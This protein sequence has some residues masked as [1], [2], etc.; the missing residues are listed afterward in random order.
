MNK[1]FIIFGTLI[2]LS[3]LSHYVHAQTNKTY[4]DD[5]RVQEHLTTPQRTL[6]PN[7]NTLH[8]TPMPSASQ[9]DAVQLTENELTQH[10]KLLNRA[11]G[12]A[13]LLNDGQNVAYLL[14]AYQKLPTH[15]QD[16][17]LLLWSKAVIAYHQQRHHDAAQYY[18][19]LL[20]QEEKYPFIQLQAIQNLLANRDF[21]AAEQQLTELSSIPNLPTIIQ[22]AITHYR[23]AI[24]NHHR[25]K[26]SGGMEYVEDSNINQAPQQTDLGTHWKAEEAQSAHGFAW[27][28]GVSKTF[29]FAHGT[30]AEMRAHLSGKYYWDSKQYN[31]ARL[32]ISLGG[33]WQNAQHSWLLLPFAEHTRYAGGKAG[34]SKM[35]HFSDTAGINTQWQYRFHPQWQ[36]NTGI[37]YA[38]TRYQTRP[39]LDGYYYFAYSNIHH[40][41]TPQ[42][43]WQL[44]LDHTHNQTQDP[45]DSYTR[46]GIHAAWGKEWHNGISTQ[47][48]AGYAKRRYHGPMPI[49][50]KTQ[51]NREYQL[52]LSLWHK[53]LHFLGITPRLM[54]QYQKTNSNIPLYRHQ[55]GRLM[56]ELNKQ[57]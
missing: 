3:P 19:Q 27:Q 45:D 12:A 15:A 11:L 43:F 13:L 41:P 8:S 46:S 21:Q 54:W 35:Q 44:G 20:A 50:M 10:P 29:S 56:L 55:K 22:Q 18:R 1:H 24:H 6:L 48:G 51:N 28:T 53:D 25:W 39:H 38:Q 49:F 47:I 17:Q 40:Q 37:E 2:C 42:Q 9:D 31:E 52:S 4:T 32:R 26:F 23:S 30:F 14:S 34:N 36:F 16:S 7:D 57:F 5:R 33:G